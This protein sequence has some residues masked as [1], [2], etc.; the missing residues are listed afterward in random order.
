MESLGQPQ[1]T[2]SQG[3]LVDEGAR[4][5]GGAGGEGA[6]GEGDVPGGI[7]AS[8]AIGALP[9]LPRGRGEEEVA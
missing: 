3:G 9:L 8:R 4:E 7:T 6:R 5:E 2:N 1:P